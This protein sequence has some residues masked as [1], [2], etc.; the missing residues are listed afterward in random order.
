MF[1][2]KDHSCLNYTGRVVYNHYVPQRTY[3]VPYEVHKRLHCVKTSDKRIDIQLGYEH[4]VFRVSDYSGLHGN[5]DRSFSIRVPKI[6]DIIIA[7]RWVDKS[8]LKEMELLG[9]NISCV[10]YSNTF[11][12]GA[13]A[14]S[15]IEN[16]YF[17]KGKCHIAY[18]PSLQSYSS[19]DFTCFDSINNASLQEILTVKNKNIDGIVSLQLSQIISLFFCETSRNPSAFLT[20][21][22]CLEL[23]EKIYSFLRYHDEQR[24]KDALNEIHNASANYQ[25]LSAEAGGTLLFVDTT[26][27]LASILKSA[28]VKDVILSLFSLAMQNAVQASREISIHINAIFQQRDVAN[29]DELNHKYDTRIRGSLADA[30]KFLKLENTLIEQYKK[31]VLQNQDPDQNINYNMI[32]KN[33]FDIDINISGE[34]DVLV[35]GLVNPEHALADMS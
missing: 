30:K 10:T 34:C 14:T 12:L 9:D 23:A 3:S 5:A 24:A 33:W 11:G 19:M 7:K 8:I 25:R 35:T 21:P 22:M 32:V 27:S 15:N 2:T 17:S 20:F 6:S 18:I 1:P 4:N 29:I 13:I 31:H 28:I 16:H 26:N